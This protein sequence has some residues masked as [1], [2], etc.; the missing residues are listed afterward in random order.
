MGFCQVSNCEFGAE[1]LYE[2]NVYVH[3]RCPFGNQ[4][5]GF[6]IS[7]VFFFLRS[8]DWDLLIKPLLRGIDP[9]VLKAFSNHNK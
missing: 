7:T 4:V 9:R 3:G 2:L 1:T 8:S 5:Y 6:L